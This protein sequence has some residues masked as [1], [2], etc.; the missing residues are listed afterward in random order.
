MMLSIPSVEFN[1]KELMTGVAVTY[2]P[3]IKKYTV[4]CHTTNRQID[5]TIDRISRVSLSGV[6]TISCTISG[7][8]H[9]SGAEVTLEITYNFLKRIYSVSGKIGCI[10][11]DVSK[12][13]AVAVISDIIK[14][15]NHRE[16]TPDEKMVLLQRRVERNNKHEK[17]Q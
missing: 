2:S 11:I 12:T 16:M 1:G 8:E 7:T 9:I 3:V 6:S 14:E 5:L 17:R 15:L 13:S 10:Q 4:K